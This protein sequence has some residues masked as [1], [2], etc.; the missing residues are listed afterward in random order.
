MAHRV[1]LLFFLLVALVLP[2]AAEGLT[3]TFVSAAAKPTTAVG[4]GQREFAMTAYRKKVPVGNVKFNIRNLGQ[5]AH[6]LVVVTPGKR[7]LAGPDVLAGK[8]ATWI[9]KLTR[10]GTYK[11]IC[12]RADHLSRGMKSKLVVTRKK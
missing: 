7:S 3:P 8:Q 5:D 2:S 11:L 6:N 12:T 1:A 9:V 4:I 10:P